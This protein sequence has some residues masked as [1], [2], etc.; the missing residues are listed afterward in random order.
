VVPIERER[1][2]RATYW[3]VRQSGAT[4][5]RD[6]CER[7]YAGDKTGAAYLNAYTI[8]VNADAEIEMSYRGGGIDG[9]NRTLD[10]SDTLE[11]AM[12]VLGTHHAV[13]LT[14]DVR[15]GEQLLMVKPPGQTQILPNT[16]IEDA[17]SESAS[18]YKQE[19]RSG[20]GVQSVRNRRAGWFGRSQ[21]QNQGQH[22]Q[23]ANQRGR[24]G[25]RGRG[26]GGRGD[27][28]AGGADHP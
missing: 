7:Y 24:G 16:V 4:S 12:N 23:G 8:A 11:T 28:A 5:L 25:D 22:Q 17:R 10:A 6:W 15:M 9:L 1:Q 14:G 3:N 26:K 21:N 20:G 13:G 2:A 18:V 19:G 27:G